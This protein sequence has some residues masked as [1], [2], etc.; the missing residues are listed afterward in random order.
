MIKCKFTKIN[1]SPQISTI[2]R[3]IHSARYSANRK[4]YLSTNR[5]AGYLFQDIPLYQ[6]I[7]HYIIE[8]NAY[9]NKV[10]I[11]LDIYNFN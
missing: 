2:S 10:D 1:V 5:R 9:S 3:D 6:L 8:S 4:T 7:K 11:D